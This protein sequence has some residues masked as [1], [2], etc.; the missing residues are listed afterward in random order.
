VIYTT[1]GGDR[2]PGVL[3]RVCA[4]RGFADAIFDIPQGPK[5]RK[6]T[7][8]TLEPVFGCDHPSKNKPA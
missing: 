6:R 3:S 2:I 5:T 4:D 7:L 8:N 1:R